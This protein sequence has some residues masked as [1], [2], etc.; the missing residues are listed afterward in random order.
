MNFIHTHLAEIVL[1]GYVLTAI[2][3]TI[4]KP[5]QFNGYEWFYDACH[6]ILNQIPDRFKGQVP[7]Q[8]KL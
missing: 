3:S 6:V 7:N 5:G 1:C 8:P 4:P 2:I